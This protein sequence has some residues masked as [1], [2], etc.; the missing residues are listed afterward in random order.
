MP[1]LHLICHF[2][3]PGLDKAKSLPRHIVGPVDNVEYGGVYKQH[4]NKYSSYNRASW[5]HPFNCS[6]TQSSEIIWINAIMQV[7]IKHLCGSLTGLLDKEFY[8][9][10][11]LYGYIHLFVLLFICCLHNIC[12]HV[13][14]NICVCVLVYAWNC[15]HMNMWELVLCFYYV[16]TRDQTQAFRLAASTFIWWA[17]LSTSNNIFL[18]LIIIF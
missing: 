9:Q 17:I 2:C 1:Q 12:V 18:A 10:N 11:H 6:V 5:T 14:C 4:C 7:I 8:I 3:L 15:L 13:L 16:S